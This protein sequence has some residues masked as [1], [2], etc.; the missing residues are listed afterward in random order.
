MTYNDFCEGDNSRKCAT[1]LKR[2]GVSRNVPCWVTPDARMLTAT[3]RRDSLS[4]SYLTSNPEAKQS[5]PNAGAFQLQRLHFPSFDSGALGIKNQ[6]EAKSLVN[7]MMRAICGFVDFTAYSQLCFLQQ[8]Q[9]AS[10]SRAGLYN[11][12]GVYFALVRFRYVMLF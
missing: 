7:L 11:T 8:E 2:T 9:R 5:I 4:F 3:E 6:F 12:L 10:L 1:L